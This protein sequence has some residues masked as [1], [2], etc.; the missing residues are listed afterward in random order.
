MSWVCE[1]R[2]STN[3]EKI[4]IKFAGLVHA[5]RPDESEFVTE[6]I[7]DNKPR[8][9]PLITSNPDKP[10][11]ELQKNRC[12]HLSRYDFFLRGI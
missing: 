1:E 2:E 7:R 3:H 8:N 5:P 11:I 12:V 9:A 6:W 10:S 4:Y